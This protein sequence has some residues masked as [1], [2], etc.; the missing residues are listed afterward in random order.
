MRRRLFVTSLSR[1]ALRRDDGG[2]VCEHFRTL[3]EDD[4]ICSALSPR[5]ERGF[6]RRNYMKTALKWFHNHKDDDQDHQNGRDLVHDPEEA[7]GLGIFALLE[8]AA[9]L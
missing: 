7:L 6:L 9:P 2:S 4:A 8:V 3:S 1:L 5:I